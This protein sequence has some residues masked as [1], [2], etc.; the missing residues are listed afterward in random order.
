MRG[1]ILKALERERASA[2]GFCPSGQ[3][4][5]VKTWVRHKELGVCGSWFSNSRVC[6]HPRRNSFSA[7]PEW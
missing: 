1:N 4:K 7:D 2:V 5:A 3:L 6:L